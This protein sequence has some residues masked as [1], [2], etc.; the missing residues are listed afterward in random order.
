LFNRPPTHGIPDSPVRLRC[1]LG[2]SFAGRSLRAGFVT[3]AAESGA[4]INRIMD[5]SRHTDPR[6]V[7]IYIRSANRYKDHAGASFL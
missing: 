6:T 2:R 3:S 1:R 4:D 7:R 5:Q